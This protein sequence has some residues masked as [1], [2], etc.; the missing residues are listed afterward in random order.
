MSTE[1]P[2]FKWGVSTAASQTEGAFDKDGKGLSVWDEFAKRK[3]KIGDK[4][5]PSVATDFYNRYPEDI[6]ILNQ[7]KIP[8][9]RFSVSWP[10]V[11]PMGTGQPNE[12]GLDFYDRLTDHLLE[13]NIVPWTTLYHWDLPHELQKRGGWCNRDILNWFGDYVNLVTNRLGDRI[14]NW[15]VLNEPMAFTGAGYLLGV[16]APGERGIGSFVSA[17]HHAALATAAGASIIRSNVA[18][19]YVGST[20]S[21][22][23]VEPHS[24]G[25]KD[26]QAAQ[27]V[28]DM[29]N[30]FFIL[31]ATGHPYPLK[32]LKFLNKIEK[33]IKPGDESKLNAN[34]DFVGVQTYTREVIKYSWT[35][36]FIKASMVSAIKRKQ[37][38]T[39]MG[40]E[41]CPESIYHVLKNLQSVPG[42]PPIIITENG[43]AF[44]DEINKDGIINDTERIAYLDNHIQ[45]MQRAM[46]EGVDV[47]GYFAWSLTDNFEWA[48][49]YRPR[50]GLVHIDYE[51]NLKRTIKES[52]K[53]YAGRI[54]D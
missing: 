46:K 17:A 40:W 35:V 34:L 8:N 3:R 32:H 43:A 16:H 28:H 42:L 30:L 50:F 36:P 39:Q 20:F 24:S 7:L 38:Y 49:G 54:K 4:S 53:W 22:S 9:F 41:V 13:N 51:N 1:N 21:Q 47:R 27:R 6:A 15:M 44:A 37:P 19:A 26:Q 33:F 31:P 45:Q 52:A 23:W 10:R 18:N 2:G 25:I 12:K 11:L 14:K 29:L 48:E 5:N